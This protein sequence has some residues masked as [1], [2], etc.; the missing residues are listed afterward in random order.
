M[1]RGKLTPELISEADFLTLLRVCSRVAPTG[2]RNAAIISCLFRSQM[3]TRDLLLARCC[4]LDVEAELLRIKLP[5]GQERVVDIDRESMLAI[6]RWRNAIASVGTFTDT[7]RLF[8]TLKGRPLAS[9][10]IRNMLRLYAKKAGLKKRICPRGLWLSGAKKQRADEQLAIALFGLG[11]A[12]QS[13]SRTISDENRQ[14][15][16]P[17]AE[18]APID[19]AV[20]W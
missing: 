2:I 8:C 10:Y 15:T 12:H 3:K 11:K 18:M 13:L 4:D 20:Y 9:V 5:N 17:S 7:S 1:V 16:V 14:R 19:Y 6:A